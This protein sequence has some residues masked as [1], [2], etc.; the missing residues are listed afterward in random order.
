MASSR[1]NHPAACQA[2][3]APA[4]VKGDRTVYGW[5][6]SSASTRPPIRVRKRQLP[7]GAAAPPGGRSAGSRSNW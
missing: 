6:P 4:A 3:V 7:A 1:T 2:Q 5:P